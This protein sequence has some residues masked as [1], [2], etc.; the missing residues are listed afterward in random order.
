ME[1]PGLIDFV[2]RF[3]DLYP[4]YA[5]T[6]MHLTSSIHIEH[7][8]PPLDYSSGEIPDPRRCPTVVGRNDGVTLTY[9]PC[10]NQIGPRPWEKREALDLRLRPPIQI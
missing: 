6:A 5:E 3:F 8:F 9:A 2:G 4:R 1:P 10:E 7:Y